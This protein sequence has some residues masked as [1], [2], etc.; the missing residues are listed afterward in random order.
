[1][2][3][4]FKSLRR[5]IITDTLADFPYKGWLQYNLHFLLNYDSL[6]AERPNGLRES[7]F[8]ALVDLYPYS[9][10]AYHGFISVGD[11]NVVALYM[12]S[13]VSYSKSLEI[14]YEFATSCS[15]FNSAIIVV[16]VVD[17]L[18][19]GK[20][21]EDVKF[22]LLKDDRVYLREKEVWDYAGD[23]FII[24]CKNKDRDEIAKYVKLYEI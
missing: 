3:K 5:H 10:K 14:A 20:F 9:G 7:F 12:S 2:L 6:G 24:D 15:D 18:D 8:E 11:I 13:I 21:L 16:D 23:C 1:M 22:M 17:G 19:F 4:E